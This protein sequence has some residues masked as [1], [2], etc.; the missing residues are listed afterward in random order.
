MYCSKC[1]NSIK[2]GQEVCLNC[3]HI[4]GYESQIS[5]PCRHCNREIPIEYKKCPFCRKKQSNKKRLFGFLVI[6][7]SIFVTILMLSILY[8]PQNYEM[9]QEYQKE[10]QSITYEELVRNN[11]QYENTLVTFTGKVVNVTSNNILNFITIELKISNDEK[12]Y[13]KYYNKDNIGILNNDI[14][15]IYGPF[16]HLS[17]NTPVINAKYIKI[18]DE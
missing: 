6:I 3:G 5:K 8:A 1:N 15:T 4:L 7:A 17:G 11:A 12:S 18:K 10:C 14:L 9:V 2:E 13:V 16:K